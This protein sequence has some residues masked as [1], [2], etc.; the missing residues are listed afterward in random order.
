MPFQVLS[1][2]GGGFLGLYGLTVLAELERET[3]RP[4]ARSF[5]LIAGTSVGGIVALG[6]A[7]EVPAEQLKAL[8][9]ARGT[10]IFS[11]REAPQSLLAKVRDLMRG[12]F[13]PKYAATA[14]R[15]A[16]DDT[17]ADRTIADLRHRV[18][19]PAVNLSKGRP[20]VFKTPHHPTFRRDL[21][22]RVVD[23]AMATSAAPTYFPLAPIGDELFAD[24]GLYANSPDLLALHEAEHFLKVPAEDV[25]MLSIGTTTAQF[26]FSHRAG[27]RLGLLKWAMGQRLVHVILSSQQLHV[28]YMMKHKLGE[29]YLR[30]DELQSSEQQRDLALDIANSDAQRTIRAIAQGSVQR[31]LNDP[32]LSSILVHRAPQVVWKNPS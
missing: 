1:L 13:A 17:F 16:L 15:Q 25:R 10:R 26:S 11:E 31:V 7:A 14:L 8:F 27:L 28:D 20:Q 4:I 12:L 24:G 18:I 21:K 3:G 29:R 2:S 19:V 9:E 32:M 23:V 30:I 22:L 6:L 5:D